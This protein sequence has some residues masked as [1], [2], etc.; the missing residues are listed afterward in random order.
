MR[1]A[2]P[3]YRFA[4]PV[5]GYRGG[6]EDSS[7]SLTVSSLAYEKFGDSLRLSLT[8]GR[9]YLRLFSAREVEPPVDC[10]LPCLC[11]DPA[12]RHGWHWRV[13]AGT[14]ASFR[15]AKLC[16]LSTASFLAYATAQRF[17]TASS[18]AWAHVSALVF[19]A[20]RYGQAQG[21]RIRKR[22]Y[23]GRMMYQGDKRDGGKRTVPV[24]SLYLEMSSRY[25]TFT[26]Y[27]RTLHEKT[28]ITRGTHD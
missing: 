15:R 23:R 10:F 7:P 22:T 16:P 19:G 13:G 25:A 4:R 6:G 28:T 9:R 21:G 1:F 20:R 3:D 24:W 27:C 8:R 11:K 12:I 14:R 5:S 18:D 26:K 2:A 17:T